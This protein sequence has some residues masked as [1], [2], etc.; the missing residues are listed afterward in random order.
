VTIAHPKAT[1]PLC[2][3][4]NEDGKICRIPIKRGQLLCARHWFQVPK[5]LRD[6]IWQLAR[7]QKGSDEHRA[8]CFEAILGFTRASL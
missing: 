7:T 3:A 5:A 6:R 2:P 4:T 8:A 1:S